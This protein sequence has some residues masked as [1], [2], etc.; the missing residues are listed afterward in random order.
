MAKTAYQRHQAEK[1]QNKW[2]KLHKHL[3]FIPEKSL[4]FGKNFKQDPLDCGNPRCMIC[5]RDKIFTSRKK[6]HLS[7][8][9]DEIL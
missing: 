6:F 9:I 7:N 5:S 4:S 3:D 8:I 1:I 2:I